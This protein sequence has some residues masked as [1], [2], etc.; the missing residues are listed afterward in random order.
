MRYGFEPFLVS[1]FVVWF[2]QN[3]NCIASHFCGHMCSAVY[4]MWF[5]VGLFFKFWAFPTRSKTNFFLC[6]LLGFKLLS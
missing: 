3:Y 2:S 1:Y 4:K 6:F 5:E